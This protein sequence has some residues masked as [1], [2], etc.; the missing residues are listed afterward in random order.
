M[1]ANA[2]VLAVAP[3]DAEIQKLKAPKIEIKS[4]LKLS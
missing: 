2:F 3:A 4:L 1:G